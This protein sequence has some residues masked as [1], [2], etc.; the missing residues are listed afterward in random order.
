MIGATRSSISAEITRQSGLAQ[1]IAKAQVQVSTQKRLQAGSDDPAAA[2]RIAAIRRE[3]ADRATWGANLNTTAATAGRVDATLGSVSSA[4]QRAIEIVTQAANGTLSAADRRALATELSGIADDVGGYMAA[5][6][7]SGDPLFPTGPVT[8]VPVG[9]GV[10]LSATA[11][12]A[13]V[14]GGIAL[15]T[16]ASG[17]GAATGDLVSIFRA[18]AAAISSNDTGAISASLTNVNA[19][20]D[21]VAEQRGLLGVQ[22]A[23]IDAYKQRLDAGDAGLA[24]ERSGLED[25]DLSVTVAKLQS[26][27][28]TLEA[29]QATFAQLNKQTLFDKLG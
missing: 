18:A 7:S 22:A 14:F 4:T 13:T 16:R 8:R 21:H 11:S 19:A 29:A 5:K 26:K 28:L 25:T 12:A 15:S 6:D 9:D 24:A 17:G 3:Q 10:T 20:A 23:R 2:A 1:E 27:L